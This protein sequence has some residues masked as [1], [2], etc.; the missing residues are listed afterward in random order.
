[1]RQYNKSIM[2][3]TKIVVI[4]AGS[5]SFGLNN[6]RDAFQS[7]HLKG[8]ELCLVDVNEERLEWMTKLAQKMNDVSGAGIKITSHTDRKKALPDA[9]FVITCVA[10]KRNE[11]WKKD[12]EIPKKYGVRHVL[13]ENGGPGGLSHAL[14]NIPIILNIARDMEKLC[15]DAWLI[16][17]T[18]PESR[19]CRAVN[20][21]SAIKTVGLCHGIFM[22]LDNVSYITGIPAHDL[23]AVASGINHFTW[24][25]KLTRKSTGDD[26]YPLLSEKNKTF[27]PKYMPFSRYLYE[28]IGLFP[29]PSDDHI[30]EYFAYAHE[31]AGEH[32][33]DFDAADMFW[34]GL[35]DTIKKM[36]SGEEDVKG[37]LSSKSGEIAFE[38][39]EDMLADKK[40]F[41][42]SVN[43]P[44][45]NFVKGVPEDAVV[46]VPCTVDAKGIHGMTCEPLP[47]PVVAMCAH[48]T[49]IQELCVDAAVKGSRKLALEALLIDP[50][51]HSA[52][53]AEKIL[54][55]F[56]SAH[57]EFLPQFYGA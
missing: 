16:N 35:W 11:L 25:H 4:G 24:M 36:A 7:T 14:R 2:K 34:E 51:I 9:Q 26:V 32:G 8:S 17:F 43:I 45:K 18:N 30:G 33:Y 42:L 3:E 40:S 20:K 55:E 46:E 54:D 31:M 38:I 44:N 21:Y 53:A 48:Q 5:V 23:E 49:H 56:L 6:L 47:E 28:K 15:P 39:I 57:K 29:S 27:N 13:G 41:R 50:V 10:M 1:M 52:S 37:L 19:I 12:W 22:G